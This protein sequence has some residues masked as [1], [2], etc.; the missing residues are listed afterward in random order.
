MSFYEFRQN[1]SGG[2]FVFDEEEGISVSVIV[3]ANSEKQ[4]IALASTIGLY[5]DGDGD[6]RCCG[7][8]WSDYVSADEIPSHYGIPLQPN[9][10]I[11][12]YDKVRQEIWKE[13]YPG[14]HFWKT[15]RWTTG[16]QAFIHYLDGRI[17][18]TLM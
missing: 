3:E 17:V 12:E 9:L 8:R 11:E 10:T 7:D 2:N 13:E 18:P 15:T 4:A 6:C 14:R 1:N 5:F 16:P